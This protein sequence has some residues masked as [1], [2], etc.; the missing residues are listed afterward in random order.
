[1]KAGSLATDDSIDDTIPPHK[2]NG[3]VKKRPK[4]KKVKQDGDDFDV[5]DDDDKPLTVAEKP[6]ISRKRKLKVE[7]DVTSGDEKPTAKKSAST[8]RGKKVKKDDDLSASET[9]KPKKRASKVKKEE[10]NGSIIKPKGKKK[11][12]SVEEEEVFR[13]W[14]ADPN[15]DGSIKW[16]TLEHNGV[17]FPPPYEPLP[18]HVKMKYNGIKIFSFSQIPRPLTWSSRGRG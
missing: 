13:W 1:M 7:T 2:V 9:S 12:D 5:S 18:K 14:D 3:N 8:T 16:Q 6:T 10:L 15:G 4:K 11:V 17:I